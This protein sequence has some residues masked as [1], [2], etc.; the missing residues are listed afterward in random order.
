MTEGN[1]KLCASCYFDFCLLGVGLTQAPWGVP[2]RKMVG[3]KPY[4]IVRSLRDEPNTRVEL[5][6]VLLEVARQS[7]FLIKSRSL[8]GADREAGKEDTYDRRKK[9]QCRSMKQTMNK[10]RKYLPPVK[11]PFSLQL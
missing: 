5:A 8:C 3:I 6:D 11:S 7:K 4:E 1:A 2:C 9:W 10:A